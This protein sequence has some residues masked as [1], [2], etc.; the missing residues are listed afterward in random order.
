M[1][2]SKISIKRPVMITMFILVFIVFGLIAYRALPLN[3]MPV[4]DMPFVTIQTVY[5][6]A[7]PQEVE[8]QI[9]KK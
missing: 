9:T 3:L 4:I 6:G 1:F 2:L 7:G 8:I 5:P